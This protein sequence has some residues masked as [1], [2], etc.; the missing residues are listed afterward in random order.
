MSQRSSRSSA[1][2]AGRLSVAQEGGTTPSLPV[3]PIPQDLA[4]TRDQRVTS[5]TDQT[6]MRLLLTYDPQ[7]VVAAA[8]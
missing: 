3:P 5:V 6:T 4:F 1:T 8:G 2:P 7:D